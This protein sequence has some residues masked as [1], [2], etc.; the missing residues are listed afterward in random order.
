MTEDQIERQVERMT[1]K[2]DHAFTTT[3]MS[4]KEYDA[5]YKAIDA[6][7]KEQYRAQARA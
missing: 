3:D 4:Q 2:L 5:R 1:D 7:A 6:W